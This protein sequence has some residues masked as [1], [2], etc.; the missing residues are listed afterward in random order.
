M[1]WGLQS[2]IN[3]LNAD[4]DRLRAQIVEIGEAFDHLWGFWDGNTMVAIPGYQ[5]DIQASFKELANAIG[6]T[7]PL[8]PETEESVG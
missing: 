3:Q 8:V 2:Q 1:I 6:E 4:C 5:D 7:R